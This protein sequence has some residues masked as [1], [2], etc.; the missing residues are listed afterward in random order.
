M[1]AT[2][3][4]RATAPTP[5]SLSLPVWVWLLALAAA[6]G[7]GY[8]GRSLLVPLLFALLGAYLLNPLVLR[9]QERGVA[10]AHAVVILFASLTLTLLVTLSLLLSTFQV[11]GQ[12]LI[13]AAP[14]FAG[15]V[16]LALDDA[17][18]DARVAWPRAAKL[19]PDPGE[20]GWLLRAITARSGETTELAG[21]AG[22]IL[23]FLILALV[24]AFFLLRDGPGCVDWTVGRIHA[25]HIETSV[26][27][28]AQIDRIIGQYLRGLAL[29]SL[30]VGILAGLGLWFLGVPFP[31]LLGLF[32]AVVNPLPYIGVL[33]SLGAA[34]LVALTS[35]MGVASLTAV[36]VL[37]AVIR[38]I[39]D[40][41]LI[42]LTI[43][44]S[45]HLHP[46]LVIASI[47]IGEHAL[48]VLGMV[49]AVPAVTVVKEVV[50][51]LLEHRRTLSGVPSTWSVHG[52]REHVPL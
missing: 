45:V 44:G 4:V 30:G 25:R 38:L 12:R 1:S 33:M 2:S 19:L 37:F 22:S 24:F 39:D 41:V 31:L 3:L 5:A 11:E 42:P 7:I 32:A 46:A 18:R 51:L 47:L 27:V 8:V 50:R 20:P 49:L 16:E 17:G 29:E 15:K 43:G 36:I 14:G 35:Q 48:G 9:L 28:W 34:G 52:D 13:E 21:H 23:L 26:A 10:R 6:G 40:L